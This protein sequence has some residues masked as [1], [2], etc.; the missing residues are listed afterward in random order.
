VLGAPPP[1]LDALA[2]MAEPETTRA[3]VGQLTGMWLNDLDNPDLDAYVASM[4]AYPD[5][6]WARAARAIAASYRQ[7]PS[8]LGAAGALDPA[9]PTLHVYVQPADPDYL[10]AQ[11]DFAAA[12]P[13]FGVQR[14]DAASHFPM[15]EVPDDMTARIADFAAS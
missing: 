9:P 11:Q 5:E 15:Y 13:W 10:R 1:F 6:M 14:L 8:P 12:H 7:D 4:A 2:G 3:V